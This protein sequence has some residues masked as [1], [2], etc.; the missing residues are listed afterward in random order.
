MIPAFMFGVELVVNVPFLKKLLYGMQARWMRG[1]LGTRAT[2]H[3]IVM[4][5]EL[6]VGD[7]VS[8]IAWVRA[9]MLR[10]RSQVD[11]RYDHER[12]IFSV[13][14]EE[15]SSWSAI[16]SRKCRAAGISLPE[17]TWD[18]Y[19]ASQRTYH[20]RQFFFYALL[21]PSA[22]RSLPQPTPLRRRRQELA[23]GQLGAV[24]G[25][26][27]PHRQL[28]QTLG[29]RS[30][31]CKRREGCPASRERGPRESP[32]QRQRL[33]IEAPAY[34]ESEDNQATTSV[35]ARLE[36]GVRAELA[37]FGLLKCQRW[38]RIGP[39]SRTPVALDGAD[40]RRVDRDLGPSP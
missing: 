4:M 37:R 11:P 6:G 27:R 18:D 28:Q 22:A 36:L 25:V 7:R 3:R 21:F 14:E 10:V 13:A 5:L 33:A 15:P 12:R 1:M 24:A 38:P 35:A 17:Q 31:R 9:T 32:E 16:L 39:G 30:Q 26:A 34:L 23:Q 40:Q 19:S 20:L 2:I 8:S 29:M